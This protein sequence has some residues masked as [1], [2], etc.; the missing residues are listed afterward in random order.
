MVIVILRPTGSY[1]YFE[2][3]L[4]E[5]D[6]STTARFIEYVKDQSGPLYEAAL[7]AHDK[8]MV[9]IDGKDWL[10]GITY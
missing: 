5:F 1:S 6:S 10:F 7:I 3:N 4:K 9:S 2:C 8:L